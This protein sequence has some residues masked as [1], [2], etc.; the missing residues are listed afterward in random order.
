MSDDNGER[1]DAQGTDKRA[2]FG[3]RYLTDKEKVFEFNAWYE[4]RARRRPGYLY[5]SALIRR[6]TAGMMWNGPRNMWTR[7]GR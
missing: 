2:K 5:F 3:S 6:L 7:P 1:T 4:G